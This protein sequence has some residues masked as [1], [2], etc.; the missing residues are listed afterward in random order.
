MV[1]Y[2]VVACLLL[3]TVTRLCTRE[4]FWSRIVEIIYKHSSNTFCNMFRFAL[5]MDSSQ[6]SIWSVRASGRR[7]EFIPINKQ[8]LRNFV[9]CCSMFGLVLARPSPNKPIS[10]LTVFFIRCEVETKFIVIV[11]LADQ[12]D[13]LLRLQ[14]LFS[15]FTPYYIYITGLM[16]LLL[17]QLQRLF[18]RPIQTVLAKYDISTHPSQAIFSQSERFI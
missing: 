10:L 18:Y 2:V 3:C 6:L 12:P 4:S 5:K 8:L 1:D 9:D 7:Q 11:R 17:N 15:F 13:I 14:R 16:T